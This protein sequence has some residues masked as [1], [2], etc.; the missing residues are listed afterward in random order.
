MA[1]VQWIEL[2]GNSLGVEDLMRIGRGEYRVKVGAR[3]HQSLG[4][5]SVMSC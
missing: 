4:S 3:S 2:D 5:S 1:T